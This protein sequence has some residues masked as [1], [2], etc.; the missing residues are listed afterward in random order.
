[1]FPNCHI[2]IHA[3]RQLAAVIFS[4]FLGQSHYSADFFHSTRCAILHRSCFKGEFCLG[5]EPPAS[6]VLP[7]SCQFV[8]LGTSHTCANYSPHALFTDLSFFSIPLY[9]CN[10][11]IQK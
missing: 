3:S 4:L 8:L 1:M 5:I 2:Q 11:S 10:M 6:V 9:R 7:Q